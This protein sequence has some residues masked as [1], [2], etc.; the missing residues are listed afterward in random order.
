[1]IIENGGKIPFD[2]TIAGFWFCFF[3]GGEE[4]GVGISF[5]FLIFSISTSR[6]NISLCRTKGL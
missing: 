5:S 2:P 6:K 4:G 3:L 1:M